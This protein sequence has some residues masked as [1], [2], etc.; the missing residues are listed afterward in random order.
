MSSRIIRSWLNGISGDQV[1]T[2]A[3][4]MAELATAKALGPG[5]WEGSLNDPDGLKIYTVG[6]NR[7][8]VGPVRIWRYH[9][10]QQLPPW[11]AL[12]FSQYAHTNRA[13]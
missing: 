13:A 12:F 7:I 9:D 10:G 4:A 1:I 11:H 8:R 6:T 5:F 2:E 3:Q